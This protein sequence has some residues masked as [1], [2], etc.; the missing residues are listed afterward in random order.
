MSQMAFG[1]GS[2][3]SGTGTAP[4]KVVHAH[5]QVRAAEGLEGFKF[6]LQKAQQVPGIYPVPRNKSPGGNWM[7][8]TTE[9]GALGG[10][11]VKQHHPGWGGKGARGRRV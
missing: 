5:T 4:C 8:P 1:K 6:V 2:L 11:K 3:V 7:L 10:H 9:T